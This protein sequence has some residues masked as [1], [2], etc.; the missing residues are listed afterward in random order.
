MLL[1]L[2]PNSG[3]DQEGAMDEFHQVSAEV[4]SAG[5]IALFG[6]IA[7]GIFAVYAP[8]EESSSTS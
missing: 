7:D 6:T 8:D 3:C 5:I 4:L 2:A 1:L